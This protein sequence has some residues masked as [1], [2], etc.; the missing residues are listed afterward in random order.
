MKAHAVVFTDKDQVEY[1]E[2]EVPEPGDNDV[3]IDV[4]YSWIS[5]GTE[6]SYLRA[7][8]IRGEVPYKEGDPWPFPIVCRGCS[9]RWAATSARRLR[10]HIKYGS[11]RRMRH[12]SITAD[13][14]SLR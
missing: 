7:E 13:W 4:E 5:T 3:V 10:R 12:R 6:S 1:K 14:C 11:C 9:N 8:R 2:I